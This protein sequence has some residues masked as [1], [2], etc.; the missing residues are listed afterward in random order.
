[1]RSFLGVPIRIRDEVYGNL[2]L[3]EKEGGGQ[4]DEEDE[5]LVVALAAAAG[6]AIDNARLYEEARRQE[7]WLRATTEIT[8]ELLSGMQS[9]EVLDLV[10][11]QALALSGADL[12]ALAVPAGDRQ[13]L[14]NTHAAGKAADEALG[15]VLPAAESLSGQVLAS[16]Q[17]V[18]VEDFRNDGRVNP[19]AREHM[20]LGWAVLLPLGPPGNVRG[21]LTV[22]RDPGSLP[23]PPK[24]VE[25]VTTFAA[26]AGIVLELAEHRHDAERLAVLQDR[27][28]IARDLH[29]LVIQ[30]LYATGMSLQGAVPLIARPEVADRV[31]SAVDALD[32]TIREIRSAIFSLQSHSDLKRDGLRAKILEVVEEMTV[33]LGFAPSLR[34]V[35]PLD[36]EVPGAVGEQLLV[37]LREALSNAA[38]HAGASSVDV[39]VDCGGDLVLRVRDN[40]KGHGRKYPPQ[41]PGEPGRARQRAGRRAAGR[42]RRGRGNRPGMAGRR[43][44]GGG[45]GPLAVLGCQV[46]PRP[47]AVVRRVAGVAVLVEDAGGVGGGLGPALHAQLGEERGDVVLDGLLGEEEALADLPVGQAL[48]DQLKDPP[49]LLGQP[50]Q[51]VGALRLIAHPLHDPAGRLRVEQGLPGGDRAHR[52]DQVGAADLL[53]HIAGRPGHDRVEERLVVTVG[54]E[55]QAGHAGH[56]RPDLPAHRHPVAVRQAHVQNRHV[57]LE[58]GDPGQ[59]RFR[60]ARLTDHGD[61]GLGFQQVMDAPADD[62]MI[63][64]QEHGDLPAVGACLAHQL[65]ALSCRPARWRPANSTVAAA[66][67]RSR[68]HGPSAAGGGPHRARQQTGRP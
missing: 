47:S 54:G 57:R 24:A 7:R 36:E 35:G 32:E 53:E 65:P 17:T 34:L 51:R 40:G 15:L 28:R 39:T 48:A 11:R 56:L 45:A 60:R 6:V 55:H 25:M 1:M 49:L 31:S 8:R 16:G 66:P 2:Y 26:Q 20:P 38:R 46:R 58:G 3:T 37:A 33:P 43:P 52:A 29:D 30:R 62:L 67:G 44:P 4:F 50:G 10:T 42:A 23:F 64:E 12:V 59:G 21:V 14:V 61:V 68:D 27:D 22:G 13:R 18:V 5:T 41:R 19:V 63:V 9:T